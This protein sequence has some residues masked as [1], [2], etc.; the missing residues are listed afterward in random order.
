MIQRIEAEKGSFTPT[1]IQHQ[2]KAFLSGLD[3]IFRREKG[4]ESF[5]LREEMK[6]LMTYQVGIFRDEPNL[7]S[8]KAK[9]KGLKERFN[10][11]GLKQKSLC[12]NN[13]LVQCLELEGMLHLSEVIVEG[14]L[15]RKESRGS[16]YRN[17]F[18]K[19]DDEHWLRHT[20][21]SKTPEGVRLDYKE[22][23]ITSY[24]PKER[25]Y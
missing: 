14:A 4:E 7:L 13:E 20:L 9:I 3:E 23:T 15:A 22:V 17:D 19:R 16:H 18:P 21:A 11:V 25:T 10:K 6:S 8:A 5:K 12:F 2:W 24:P 1:A